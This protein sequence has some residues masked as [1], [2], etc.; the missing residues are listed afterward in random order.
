[1]GYQNLTKLKRGYQNL[2]KLDEF[3]ENIRQH[4]RLVKHKYEHIEN[5]NSF[6]VGLFDKYRDVMDISYIFRDAVKG[7]ILGKESLRDLITQKR[8][9]NFINKVNYYYFYNPTNLEHIRDNLR[10]VLM[11]YLAK[12]Y[13]ETSNTDLAYL[14][15]LLKECSGPSM[16]VLFYD[17]F[18]VIQESSRIL[19]K[20]PEI[21]VFWSKGFEK[22]L[23]EHLL[24]IYM[25]SLSGYLLNYTN[26]STK[27][28]YQ[29][30]MHDFVR[31]LI[32][33][34]HLLTWEYAKELLKIF[35]DLR[36]NQAHFTDVLFSEY[37]HLIKI[38]CRKT[39]LTQ[40]VNNSIDIKDFISDSRLEKLSDTDL[41]ILSKIIKR[42][43]NMRD[44]DE[45]RSFISLYL[46]GISPLKLNKLANKINYKGTPQIK[47]ILN[48]DSRGL[49]ADDVE[50]ILDKQAKSVS[51]YKPE[52]LERL[53]YAGV[54]EKYFK[55]KGYKF[56]FKSGLNKPK[57]S[58]QLS[59]QNIPYTQKELQA[60]TE[61]RVW[62]LSIALTEVTT[63]YYYNAYY[64]DYFHNIYIDWNNNGIPDNVDEFA[65][66]DS[67]NRSSSGAGN[68]THLVLRDLG[69]KYLK[70]YTELYDENNKLKGFKPVARAYFYGEHN[71][72][73]HAGMYSDIGNY[74]NKNRNAYTNYLVTSLFLCIKFNRLIDDVEDIQGHD[75]KNGEFEVSNDLYDE[76]K[77]TVVN[78]NFWSNAY[79]GN[80][81]STLGTDY[82]LIKRQYLHRLKGGIAREYF[83]ILEKNIRLR[84][85]LRLSETILVQ[86][87][88]NETKYNATYIIDTSNQDTGRAF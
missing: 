88:K 26:Y 48:A 47:D 55:I 70:F 50:A 67:C 84:K 35:I 57:L 80:D 76:Y 59:K 2:P 66:A 53:T 63:A 75:I 72:F 71:N 43:T 29:F 46:R 14:L 39:N 31:T 42:F 56:K 52:N 65:F 15:L 30:G 21:E 4:G 64:E 36:I 28:G 3:M 10:R 7:R 58:K 34:S 61:L 82:G 83:E 85:T 74:Y 62:F 6:A 12:V 23:S 38:I 41:K 20:D 87:N 79:R 32:P 13:Q 19:D 17:M 1:M 18:E 37:L 49:I 78:L 86:E 60:F 9:K 25:E 33:N 5:Y 77:D 51:K 22:Q 27:E 44:A 81:Y 24:N 69:W 45:V 11:Y 68:V 54:I 73:A 16:L 40:K 8:Q